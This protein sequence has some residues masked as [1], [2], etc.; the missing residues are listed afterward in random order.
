MTLFTLSKSGLDSP[1]V[2]ISFAL[3]L[4]QHQTYRTIPA[5]LLTSIVLQVGVMQQLHL[6][7][8]HHQEV[9]HCLSFNGQQ[10]IHNQ[11]YAPV[12]CQICLFHIAPAELTTPLFLSHSMSSSS[13]KL[14]SFYKNPA[15][16]PVYWHT[17]KRGP[18]TAVA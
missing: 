6:L 10:H 13:P 12:N 5:A 15:I 4:K 1:Q 16:T 14:F 3:E 8:A 18:P 17:Y 9:E 2:L 11:E 7:L